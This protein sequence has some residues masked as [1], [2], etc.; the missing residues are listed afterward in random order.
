MLYAVIAR[1]NCAIYW[2][3]NQANA[4]P[5]IRKKGTTPVQK[6]LLTV[7]ITFLFSPACVAEIIAAAILVEGKETGA[8]VYLRRRPRHY[9][10][11]F[12]VSNRSHHERSAYWPNRP[13]I[14][15]NRCEAWLLPGDVDLS[16][17]RLDVKKLPARIAA[18]QEEL[19]KGP[20][21]PGDPVIVVEWLQEKLLARP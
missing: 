9:C 4:M 15:S 3:V 12:G 14:R 8:G 6:L 5:G 10:F 1:Q 19:C 16:L 11:S 13:A 17:L 21:W 2:P 20:P 7:C 18:F